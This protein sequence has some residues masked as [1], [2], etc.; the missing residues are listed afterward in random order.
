MTSVT[1]GASP[2]ISSADIISKIS[3]FDPKETLTFDYSGLSA[4]SAVGSFNLPNDKNIIMS[5][6]NAYVPE[7]VN[8][9][10]MTY[11]PTI[12]P[13]QSTNQFA[14]LK[15]PSIVSTDIINISNSLNSGLANYLA[16]VHPPTVS[17]DSR[18]QTSPISTGGTN[19]IGSDSTLPDLMTPGGL[20]LIVVIS[21]NS[22]LVSISLTRS[23][24][25]TKVCQESPSTQITEQNTGYS[26]V[27][28]WSCNITWFCLLLIILCICC[29]SY[30]RKI[31][32]KPIG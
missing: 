24:Y 2:N 19:I 22:T 12:T 14:V 29:I 20:G 10:I 28:F 11:N 9:T 26:A 27:L 15:D 32:K 25:I 16:I 30:T 7:D 23:N 1:T 18:L 13:T 3:S 5:F 31:T 17:Y 21:K 6:Y 4:K 8:L